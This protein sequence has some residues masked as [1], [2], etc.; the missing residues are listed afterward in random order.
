LQHPTDRSQFWLL[1][2]KDAT[3]W[4]NDE[5]IAAGKRLVEIVL[6]C[7]ARYPTT[8]PVVIVTAALVWFGSKVP[9]L[10]W[11]LMPVVS[12]AGC[13]LASS[14]NKSPASGQN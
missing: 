10:G 1:A 11:L 2:I 6:E 8:T 4:F 12:A 7:S 14:T 13:A 3:V 5:L 9:I